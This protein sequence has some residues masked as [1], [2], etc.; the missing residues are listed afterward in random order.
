M[1]VLKRWGYVLHLTHLRLAFKTKSAICSPTWPRDTESVAE[2]RAAPKA[3][4]TNPNEALELPP[5]NFMNRH[6]LL[7]TATTLRRCEANDQRTQWPGLI[8]LWHLHIPP[9]LHKNSRFSSTYPS[10]HSTLSLFFAFFFDY[11]HLFCCCWWCWCCG[12]FEWE[13]QQ[14]EQTINSSTAGVKCFQWGEF[15]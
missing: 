5:F 4:K 9:N 8:D 15:A 14:V 11:S 3:P 12:A 1:R 7:F 6:S 2:T 10:T 13:C